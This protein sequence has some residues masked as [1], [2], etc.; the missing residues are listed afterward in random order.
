MLAHFS[1]TEFFRKIRE[2]CFRAQ[3][4]EEQN[5]ANGFRAGQEHDEPVDADAHAVRGRHFIF[6]GGHG[7]FINDFLQLAGT[8]IQS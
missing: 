5:V 2:L 8:V 3:L 1:V 7:V 6:H 4:R